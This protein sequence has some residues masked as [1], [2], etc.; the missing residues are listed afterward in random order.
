MRKKEYVSSMKSKTKKGCKL[1]V[2]GS[3]Q[4]A[5]CS[6]V[7]NKL[8]DIYN[9]VYESKT[10]QFEDHSDLKVPKALV[11]CTQCRYTSSII[12]MK[13]HVYMNASFS[14]SK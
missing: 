4:P 2:Q 10:I 12:Q 3:H 14:S 1:L 7:F 5:I 9:K 8:P 13:I 11:K 6:Y